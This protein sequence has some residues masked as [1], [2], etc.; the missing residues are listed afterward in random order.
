VLLKCA[1]PKCSQQW[2]YLCEGKLFHLAPTPRIQ[3]LIGDSSDTLDERFW[4]CDR[5]AK[6][7]TLV[8]GGTDVQLVPLS[9]NRSLI[10][11]ISCNKLVTKGRTKTGE[12]QVTLAR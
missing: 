3:A 10:Q 8:W 6:E 4:L 7:M 2:H 9:Q 1:N 11:A 12:R 5:C